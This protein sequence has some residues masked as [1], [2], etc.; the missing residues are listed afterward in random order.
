MYS[1]VIGIL[2]A[3]S[4]AIYLLATKVSDLTEGVYLR[5]ADEY[6]AAIVERIRPVGGV[7][8]PGEEHAASAPTV[9]TPAGPEPV[10]TMM[11]GPQVYN[12]ACLACHG[13]GIGGAPVL[14]DA[15]QWAERIAQ[16]ASVL[17]KHALQGYSGSGSSFMPPKGGRLDLSDAEVEGAVDYMISESQ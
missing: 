2:A 12:T 6:K 17:K 1:L 9:E 10:A 7:Y 4:L 11:S 3:V 13:A 15:T 14:G 8:L 5:D 16:G